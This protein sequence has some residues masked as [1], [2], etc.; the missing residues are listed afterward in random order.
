[1]RKQSGFTLIEL[2]IVVAIIGILAAIAIPAYQ[3]Y[4]IRAKVTEGINIGSGGKSGLGEWVM[5]KG[6]CPDSSGGVSANAK[7][8]LSEPTEIVS[9]YVD[10]VTVEDSNCRIVVD[11]DENAID[12]NLNG[13]I[14]EAI[15]TASTNVNSNG[16]VTTVD[17]ACGFGATEAANIKYLPA[18]CRGSQYGS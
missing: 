15:L 13:T 4:T 18:E 11:F 14:I 9:D 16:M 5:A 12:T 1:M 7:S 10:S 17:W 3:D 6:S 8:G 2:M